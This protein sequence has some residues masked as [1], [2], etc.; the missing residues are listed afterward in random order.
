MNQQKRQI[1]KRK[2]YERDNPIKIKIEKERIS[3]IQKER[4]PEKNMQGYTR[5]PVWSVYL[6]HKGKWQEAHNIHRLFR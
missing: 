1:I 6:H 3:D 5:R 4:Q 2:K